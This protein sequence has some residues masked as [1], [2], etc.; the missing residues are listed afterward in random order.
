MA[1]IIA[2]MNHKGGVG[3]TTTTI[4][5]G[6]QAALKG[7]TLLID[8]DKQAHLSY[9]FDVT[10]PTTTVRDLFLNNPYQVVN[11]RKNLDLLPCH[12]TMAG[13]ENR[14]I[15]QFSREYILKDA[16]KP[17]LEKYDYIFLDCPPDIG[18]ITTNA[19]TAANYVIAPVEAEIF[20]VI[21]ASH[22]IDFIRK[23][24]EKL[25]P[26]LQILG[27]LLTKYV[28]NVNITDDILKEIKAKGWE[29]IIFETKI[30]INTSIKSAQF[31]KQTIFEF[32]RKS[33]GA[34]DYA[35]L[36]SEIIKKIKDN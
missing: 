36:G 29:D 13:I 7:K 8:L 6:A 22:I 34:E 20:S 32:D 14:L 26:D 12:I 21:G 18:L 15:D 11:V 10:E 2:V 16:L 4:N 9:A 5:V 33:R 27:F 30:R 28:E 25:N 1:I 24:R 35:R 19:L 3:K 31:R 23:I 17:I